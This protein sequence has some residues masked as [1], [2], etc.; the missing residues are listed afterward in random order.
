M[1]QALKEDH[2]LNEW[3]TRAV[4]LAKGEGG[5]SH[6]E[7][8]RNMLTYKDKHAKR[9]NA[10]MRSEVSNLDVWE[11]RTGAF[12]VEPSADELDALKAR[13]EDTNTR[14]STEDIFFDP[15]LSDLSIG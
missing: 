2:R 9:L 8:S 14:K 15:L 3:G 6:G 12:M 7:G 1:E 10:H 11:S 4:A 5:G 13:Q